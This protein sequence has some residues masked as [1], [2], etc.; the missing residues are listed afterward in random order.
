MSIFK[1]KRL[2]AEEAGL[3]KARLAKFI[4]K[5]EHLCEGARAKLDAISGEGDLKTVSVSSEVLDRLDND[6]KFFESAKSSL[7][8][9]LELEK[10]FRSRV[11]DT[12]FYG[13]I[14]SKSLDKLEGLID[15]LDSDGFRKYYSKLIRKFEK[16]NMH[17]VS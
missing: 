9:Q 3:L 17:I 6:I 12:P 2:S 7:A 4:D 10:S 15:K 14:T 11:N 1:K 13:I 8:L 5:L 16:Q